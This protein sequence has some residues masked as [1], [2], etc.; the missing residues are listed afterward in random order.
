MV[1]GYTHPAYPCVP[2]AGVVGQQSRWQSSQTAWNRGEGGG[3]DR[4]VG[5]ILMPQ[6]P[7]EIGNGQK[8][9]A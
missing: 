9:T 4:L 7:P 1:A 6:A 2:A 5:K 8:E 3:G